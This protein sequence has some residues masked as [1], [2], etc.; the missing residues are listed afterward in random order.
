[1][2]ESRAVWNGDM[3]FTVDQD[4]HRFTIDG[5]EEFG[6]HDRGPRPKNLLLTALA[7]CTGM[8]VVSILGKMRLTGFG[9][10]VRVRGEL[11]EDHPVVFTAIAVEY[12]FTGRDLPLEKLERAV[13]LSQEKYCGVAAMLRGS[14]R[15]THEITILEE[16]V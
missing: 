9:L 1:M 10:E 5:S 6:G 15:I 7:G 2:A 12:R 3:D 11:G 13:T 4:G 14:A 16:E 8:D